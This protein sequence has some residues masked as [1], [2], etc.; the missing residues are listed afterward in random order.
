M[1]EATIC[2]SGK[3]VMTHK[4]LKSTADKLEIDIKS[5]ESSLKGHI[6]IIDDSTFDSLMNYMVVI[7]SLKRPDYV[8]DNSGSKVDDISEMYPIDA[9]NKL[10]DFYKIGESPVNSNTPKKKIDEISEK[11]KKKASSRGDQMDNRADV[12]RRSVH[13]RF[14]RSILYNIK[15]AEW[16]DFLE[17]AKCVNAFD[18][19]D[20]H[21]DSRV[22][23][24]DLI[25]KLIG[26]N[27]SLFNFVE[28]YC[29]V[30]GYPIDL[31]QSLPIEPESPVES[32][33]GETGSTWEDAFIDCPNCGTMIPRDA[34]TC[35]KCGHVLRKAP[36][37][38]YRESS[39]QAEA[40]GASGT[41]RH[42]RRT[43]EGYGGKIH[44]IAYVRI[45]YLMI[46]II[47]WGLAFIQVIP[48]AAWWENILLVGVVP[49]ACLILSLIFGNGGLAIG[50]IVSLIG[51]A[52]FAYTATLPDETECSYLAVF[53]AATFAACLAVAEKR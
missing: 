32:S 33:D 39:G 42:S 47:M 28:S 7:D 13:E 31:T 1:S 6:E 41:S 49:A 37:T 20:S 24:L 4:R 26:G 19:L 36:S 18:Y 34:D 10:I 45:A 27:D 11:L 2:R 53:C 29:I 5:L 3:A 15:D 8:E 23:N 16:P 43:S 40:A 38:V 52:V 9:L 50:L 25:S 44:P 48:Y 51:C 21:R 22:C 35:W 14:L 30:K 12:E 17:Y 46:F